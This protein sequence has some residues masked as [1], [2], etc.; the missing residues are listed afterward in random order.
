MA[1]SV[2]EFDSWLSNKLIE[3]NPNTDLDVFVQYI[4]SILDTEG[5]DKDELL[6]S[7]SGIIEEINV[8]LKSHI[9]TQNLF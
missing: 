2:D 3:L 1:T 4:R 8:C 6:D 7:L 9:I 5:E